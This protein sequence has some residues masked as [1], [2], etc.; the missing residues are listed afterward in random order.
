MVIGDDNF[1]TIVTAIEQGRAI[2]NNILRFIHYL[3]SCNFAEIAT[4]FAAIMLGWP[5]PLAAL[6][7]LWL[8]MITD[9]FPA[10]ALA[11]EPSAPGVMSRAPR[12][13]RE[14]LVTRAFAWLI[15]WQ[16]LLISAV[17]LA[18]FQIGMQRHGTDGDGLR[19]AVTVAFMT[20]ALAQV[21]HA[22]NVRSRTRSAF[23]GGLFANR[24]LW[25]AVLLCILLQ[26]AAVYLPVLRRVL[27][28]VPPGRPDWLLI[29]AAAITPVLAVELV[30]ALARLR[31]RSSVTAVPMT[32]VP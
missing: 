18:A 14:P 2:V 7:I 23:S 15:A 6:Q 19:R 5:L 22:F 28:T 13:P 24:W 12:N 10:L 27:Q 3:F 20:L 25:G 9:I 26:L 4:V 8:N 17:T 30:K 29:G 21:F 16:G 32:P 11:L 1:A 31:S